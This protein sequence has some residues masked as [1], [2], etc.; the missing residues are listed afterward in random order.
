M[1]PNGT[2]LVLIVSNS[3]SGINQNDKKDDHKIEQ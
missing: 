1:I 3:G 2:N